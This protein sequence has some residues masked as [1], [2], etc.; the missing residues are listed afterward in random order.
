[1]TQTTEPA[2]RLGVLLVGGA[3]PDR[4]LIGEMLQAACGPWCELECLPADDAAVSVLAAGSED[5]CLLDCHTDKESGLALLRNV[6]NTGCRMPVVVLVDGNANGTDDEEWLSAGAADC[7]SKGKLNPSALRRVVRRAVDHARAIEALKTSEDALRQSEE[8]YRS[9]IQNAVYGIY[10]STIGGRFAEVNRALVA[11]LGYLSDA[12]L[13]EVGIENLYADPTERRRLIDRLQSNRIE[14]IETQWKRKDGSR[15]TVRLSGRVLRSS[16]GDIDGFEMIVEDVTERRLLESQFRQAQK[17]EAIGRLAGGIAHDFNNLLTAMLGYSDLLLDQFAESDPSRYDVLEIKKAAERASSL[18]RQ[19]LAFSRKQVLQPKPLDLNS[20]VSG[21][22]KMLR[23]LIGEDVELITALGDDLGRV[24]ADPGQVEQIIM[25]L[26]VNARDAMPNGGKLIIE[27]NN[28]E[29]DAAYARRHEPV[30]PGRYVVLAVSDTGCGM[31]DEVKSHLFEPFFS[32][33][34]RGKGTGLG[35]ATVYGIVKQS[36]GYIWVYSEPGRGASFKI[37]LPR[38]DGTVVDAA[39][40]PRTSGATSGDETVLVV[41]DEPAVRRLAVEVLRRHGYQ[42]LEAADGGEA[43]K[44]AERHPGNIHV[45]ITDLVMPEMNGVDLAGRLIARRPAT[46]VLYISG[47]T[48][49]AVARG[50]VLEPGTNFLQKPFNSYRL[51]STV[52]QVLDRS[53]GQGLGARD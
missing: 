40:S 18:T 46:R 39:G 11:M 36:G 51:A 24:K 27:T 14:G 48:D 34:E 30:I 29:L 9:L 35:L 49:E 10:H 32:T 26:A 53:L 23:R 42:V 22:D 43:M 7:L 33:K 8:R 20:I 31:D 13:M 47:Y 52:R 45:L 1:M 19:L 2:K 4:A 12:E 6:L 38:I 44:V 50:G 16:E 21:F 17:M 15:I 37:Y 25:N 41:E 3:A 5:I 28:V